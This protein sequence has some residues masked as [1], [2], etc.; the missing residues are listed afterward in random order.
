MSEYD[1]RISKIKENQMRLLMYARDR[2]AK[3][4]V[5]NEDVK[6]VV[7]VLE[8]GSSITEK[9]K[10][11]IKAQEVI[12]QCIDE[13]KNADT[14]KE[15]ERI[16]EKLEHY[17][18]KIKKEIEER[19]IRSS[20]CGQYISGA[21]SLRK[22]ISDYVRYL[23][24]EAKINEI[25]VLNSKICLTQEERARLRELLKNELSYGKRNLDKYIETPSGDEQE[26]PVFSTVQAYPSDRA[27]ISAKI[28][29]V[30]MNN[31]YDII[32]PE[33]YGESIKGNLRIFARNVYTL[34]HN[35]RGIKKMV[36]DCIKY[37]YQKPVLFGCALYF[38]SENSIINSFK[39][40]IK[41]SKL[42]NKDD[43]YAREHERC[44]EFIENY[45]KEDDIQIRYFYH[46]SNV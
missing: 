46:S 16:R 25:E 12:E 32:I 3:A 2:I 9:H 28:N 35:K 38:R 21:I 45:F 19:N 17:I 27:Y 44:I 37:E 11:I 24:R 26:E 39:R 34:F 30:I 18:R 5:F 6:N 13:I 22:G 43:F 36:N 29:A 41:G 40:A 10:A 4:S 33:E 14:V 31:E 1:E 23:R 20:E 8:Y 7:S 15:I 42:A